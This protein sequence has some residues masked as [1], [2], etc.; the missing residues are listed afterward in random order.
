MPEFLLR[1]TSPLTGYE[2]ALD[3][4]EE[5]LNDE[6]LELLERQRFRRN[7]RIR[8][9]V[10]TVC[11]VAGLASAYFIYRGRGSNGSFLGF[12]RSPVRGTIGEM[13]HRVEEGLSKTIHDTM[14]K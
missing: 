3:H 9:R 7:R 5:E 11:L 14:G 6:E 4:I 8:R 10:L 13:A 12:R 2:T 1:M